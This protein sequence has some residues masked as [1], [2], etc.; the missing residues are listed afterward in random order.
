MTWAELTTF[1]AAMFTITNPI[2]NAALFMAMASERPEAERRRIAVTCALASMIILVVVVWL[3]EAVLDFFGV[4]VA[5]LPATGGLVIVLIGMSM[6]HANPSG[7]H[8]KDDERDDAKGKDSIA[9]VPLA[10]PIVAGPGTITTVIVTTHKFVGLEN[11]IK[12]A[13][14]CIGAAAVV[15][16]FFV[17][18]V[19]LSRVLG[20]TGINILTRFMGL[21]L[22]AIAIGM[23]A[24]G[25]KTLM[26][27]LAG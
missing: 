19:T 12:I 8:S 9:I 21:I 3:G 1:A 5:A 2:G 24:E 23:L 26:P 4:S 18:A 15:G 6:L 13:L 14:I 16:V 22:V 25:L 7:V 17:A 11:N 20:A 27:G 10:M